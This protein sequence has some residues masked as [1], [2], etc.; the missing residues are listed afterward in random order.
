[1]LLIA[2]ADALAAQE[3][4][5]LRVMTFNLWGGGESGNQPL[6][7]TAMVVQRAQA[8]LVGL[9]EVCGRE[10]D[11][12]RPDNG[13]RIAH[14]LN[15]HYVSQGD[16]DTGVLSRHKIVDQTPR[17][18]GVQI[19]LPSGRRV[20]LFNVH[21]AHAPYQPYQLLEI[22][23][24]DAPFLDTAEEAVAAARAARQRQIESMLTE[25][26][27]VRTDDA[28]IFVTGDFNEPSALDWTEA[29]RTAGHC[30]VAVEWP[31]S[32]AVMNAGFVD[33]YR[34]V[35]A[36]S[37]AKR[38]Y[39]WTPTTAADDPQDHHDRIDLVFVG[40]GNARVENSEV[41]G[42]AAERADII[43]APYPSD[44]RAVVATIALP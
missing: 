43:V 41:V 23:Y 33:A 42:E 14:L 3:P 7:Q 16:D 20:W 35:H 38:G 15:M 2:M 9:Q 18:W 4:D 8:D 28:T 36:D 30:P 44:H 1:M 10:R 17:K 11:G 34:Q 26:K 39:T 37:V 31:T 24:H 29:A 6:E 5:M 32:K 27:A 40:G 12:K 19:Q 22:P 21:L 25:L 13:E